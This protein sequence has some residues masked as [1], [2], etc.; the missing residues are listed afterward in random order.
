M[1]F[2]MVDKN[3]QIANSVIQKE[4]EAMQKLQ[5]CIDKNFIA[6]VKL[7]AKS[8]GRILTSGIGKSGLIGRK[9]SACF[10][11]IGIPSF[12]I[13]PVEAVHGDLGSF[14][15]DDILIALSHSGNTEEMKNVVLY[16]KKHGIKSIGITS[17]RNSFLGKECDIAIVYDCKEEAIDGFPVPTTS[18]ILVLAICDALTACAIKHRKISQE[19][20]GEWHSGGTIGRAMRRIVGKKKKELNKK[21]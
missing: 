17:N 5:N 1:H 3:I 13:H 20:Y 2:V 8:K 15:S 6:A 11:S 10:A 14:E 21:K 19:Q 18:C 9:V 4:I 12:S 7:I 16:C